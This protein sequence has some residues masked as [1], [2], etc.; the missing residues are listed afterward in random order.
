MPQNSAAR[1][2]GLLPTE[3]SA[4][5]MVASGGELPKKVRMSMVS[6]L[7]LPKM[8]VPTTAGEDQTRRW[9]AD[10]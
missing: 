5:A 3:L 7:F 4:S 9:P 2:S 6:I 8:T 10:P 1:S